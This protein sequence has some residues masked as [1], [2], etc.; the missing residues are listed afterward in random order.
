MTTDIKIFQ[1]VVDRLYRAHYG[2]TVDDTALSDDRVAG[3]YVSCGMR[4]HEAVNELA[5]EAGLERIDQADACFHGS[6]LLTG[7]DEARVLQY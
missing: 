6:A 3:S 4:P 2:I 7:E 5:E 1:Q